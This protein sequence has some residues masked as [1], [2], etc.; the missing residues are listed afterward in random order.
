MPGYPQE[1]RSGR[2]WGV[3][4]AVLIRADMAVGLRKPVRGRQGLTLMLS[5]A[6]R[7]GK[8]DVDRLV[9]GFEG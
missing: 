5:S 7:P 1:G 9:V 6:V 3:P 8:G 4:S 2:C